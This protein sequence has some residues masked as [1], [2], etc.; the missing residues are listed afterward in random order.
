MAI[1]QTL[2]HACGLDEQRCGACR[3]PYSEPGNLPLCP[4]CRV[5]VRCA[6]TL[7]GLCGRPLPF[8]SPDGGVCAFC[9]A[10]P[11]PWRRLYAVGSYEGLLR[12]LL[13]RA[14]YRA[15]RSTCRLLGRL[16]VE[17]L[18][19]QHLDAARPELILPVPLHPARLRQRGFNQ[20]QEIAEPVSRLLGI[21]RRPDLAR[22][23]V[24]T[25]P[26]TGLHRDE[27]LRNLQRAFSVSPEVRG[28][29]LL[30]L[31]DTVTTGTTLRRLAHCLLQAGASEVAAAAIAVVPPHAAAI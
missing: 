25:P 23:I 24:A 7:C 3:M 30:I 29:R 8:L 26:Q 10:N 18:T 21:P 28:R 22:R 16:L 5:A 31:D 6:H 12:D 14:K 1:L 11:P 17:K 9:L 15:D 4:D 13:L 19:A 20:C 2:L 27:R